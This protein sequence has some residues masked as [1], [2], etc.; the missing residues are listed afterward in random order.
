MATGQRNNSLFL[1]C[2]PW[3]ISVLVHTSGC[4]CVYTFN[5]TSSLRPTELHSGG[6][7]MLP[8]CW[9]LNHHCNNNT[10][11]D[12]VQTGKEKPADQ[13]C[14]SVS[15][16]FYKNLTFH[17]TKAYKH[18]HTHTH[19]SMYLLHAGPTCCSSSSLSVCSMKVKSARCAESWMCL[20][21][22][23]SKSAIIYQIYSQVKNMDNMTHSYISV[24]EL[25]L[26]LKL[27]NYNTPTFIS[28]RAWSYV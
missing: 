18:K 11:K 20:R 27:A 5:R 16:N 10:K 17:F 22:S 13:M 4:V 9:V 25:N 26:L 8:C 7:L 3:N 24:H 23:S 2:F 21:F 6:S 14:S 19:C 1:I 15:N 28:S 12:T